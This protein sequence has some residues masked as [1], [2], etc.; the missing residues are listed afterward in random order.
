MAL[1]RWA[2]KLAWIWAKQYKTIQVTLTSSWWSS[3]TQ[4][5][6]VSWVTAN[7]TVI[8]SPAPASIEDYVEAKIYCTAQWSDTLTFTCDSEPSNDIVVN[9]VILY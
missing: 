1:Y 5:V 3:N 7:N 8:A 2:T 6:L 9:I 4:T